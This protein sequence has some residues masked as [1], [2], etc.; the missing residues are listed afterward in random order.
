M[1]RLL[2]I[3]IGLVL[4][5][6]AAVAAL[7]FQAHALDK[8]SQAFVANEV[9]VISANWDRSLI[10]A[11]ATP[12]YRA[13]LRTE[14][15]SVM[16][17]ASSELGPPQEYLGATGAVSVWSLAMLGHGASASFTAQER[18]LNGIAT[19]QFSLVKRDGQWMIDDFDFRA[20][21][22]DRLGPGMFGRP[23]VVER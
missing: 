20:L 18:F 17:E 23:G 1:R 13:Q 16:E 4:L 6:G 5:F 12:Q 10:I 19:M 11:H 8:E 2:L 15:T 3:A 14:R 7:G 22:F 9:A 21:T